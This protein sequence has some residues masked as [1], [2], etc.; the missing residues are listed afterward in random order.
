M[1]KGIDSSIQ[2][3]LRPTAFEV[4]NF[5]R[6]AKDECCLLSTRNNWVLSPLYLHLC[7]G[8]MWH[9][10][11]Y[12]F[13]KRVDPP[14]TNWHISVNHESQNHSPSG[15]DPTGSWMPRPPIFAS[16]GRHYQPSPIIKLWKTDTSL[17][18][19]HSIAYEP[20]TMKK[21]HQTTPQTSHRALILYRRRRFINH[22]LTYLQIFIETFWPKPPRATMSTV[23]LFHH[24]I[25][26]PQS[27]YWTDT[28]LAVR[29][30]IWTSWSVQS[31]RNTCSQ[32]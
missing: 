18:S 31:W 11:V 13:L 15:I 19:S 2:H 10:N 22:L 32:Y 29:T 21:V 4:L 30:F 20:K 3:G 25:P 5:W 27:P 7:N 26:M 23:P 16:G 17:R 6:A 8:W 28:L 9:T 14:K 1:H 12:F 24:S